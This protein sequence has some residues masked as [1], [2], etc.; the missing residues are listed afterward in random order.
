MIFSNLFLPSY[1]YL[2]KYFYI[3]ILDYSMR[4]GYGDSFGF[5]V[6]VPL[7][8]Q[9]A[10]DQSIA[11]NATEIRRGC[12]ANMEVVIEKEVVWKDKQLNTIEA[13]AEVEVEVQMG[14]TKH[15]NSEEDES[16][17]SWSNKNGNKT[18][19]ERKYDENIDDI[20]SLR[21]S[22]IINDKMKYKE[23]NNNIEKQKGVKD[24][25][26]EEDEDEENNHHGDT[27]TDMH[28]CVRTSSNSFRKYVLLLNRLKRGKIICNL[29]I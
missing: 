1:G 19:Y 2:I 26:V 7:R 22:D 18:R 17:G 23:K 15:Y 9:S 25:E 14:E 3:F 16:S 24:D 29:I 21:S 27:T 10:V 13:E 28:R 11:Y 5:D 6:Y 12:F 8:T 4:Y 20:H